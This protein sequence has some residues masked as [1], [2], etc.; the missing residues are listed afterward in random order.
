M[1]ENGVELLNNNNNNSQNQVTM[2]EDNDSFDNDDDD[3]TS[4][5]KKMEMEGSKHVHPLD[6]ISRFVF[7]NVYI[8]FLI[9]Y[10]FSYT[11]E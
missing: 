11:M 7:P 2:N 9:V 3:E 8:V 1:D 4:S 10:F 6:R 5:K